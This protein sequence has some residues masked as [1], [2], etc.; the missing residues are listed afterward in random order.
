MTSLTVCPYSQTNAPNYQ[1]VVLTLPIDT[2]HGGN[3]QALGALDPHNFE[4][5]VVFNETNSFTIGETVTVTGA[6]TSVAGSA[7]NAQIYNVTYKVIQ[8]TGT[9][10]SGLLTSYVATGQGASIDATVFILPANTLS[11]TLSFSC[12]NLP[13]NSAC[14]FN[15]TVITLTPNPATPSVGHSAFIPLTIT[16][17]TDLQPGE[18]NSQSTSLH[19]PAIPG[20]KAS[21][22]TL[23]LLLGWPVTLLGLAGLI[24]FR[25]RKGLA[26]SFTLTALLFMAL[27]SS[28]LFTAGCGGGPGAYK[29]NLTPT[30]VYP[31][32]VT[33]TNGTVT[34]SLIVDLA[35]FPGTAGSE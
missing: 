23:A 35:I 9:Q 17:F 19:A 27:G 2:T 24:R 10:W 32:V 5:A 28:V 7:N 13:A 12:A 18:T 22:V 31:V 30:G 15:P 6:T 29:A 20:H 21:G 4:Q 25:K 26:S 1:T 14:T 3:C 11:G 16:F 33:V 8:A 34:Q